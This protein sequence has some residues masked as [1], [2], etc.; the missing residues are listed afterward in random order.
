MVR[1]P[2]APVALGRTYYGGM[3]APPRITPQEIEQMVEHWVSTP[4]GSYLGSSY[5][6]PLKDTLQRPQADID[7][8]M[9]IEKLRADIPILGVLPTG[10][11]NVYAYA[12]PQ[13]I[14]RTEIVIEVGGRE[15]SVPRS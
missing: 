3:N 4:A 2:G 11:V 1:K 5:G 8:D 10:S 15:I 7:A 6:N 12:D 9:V 13:Y 14:D